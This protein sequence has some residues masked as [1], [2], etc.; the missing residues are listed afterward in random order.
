MDMLKLIGNFFLAAIL[1]LNLYGCVAI[2]A[3]A[4]GGAGTAIW[5]EGKISEQ[6]NTPLEETLR[7]TKQALE[8]LRLVVTKTVVKDEVAQVMAEYYD[9]RTV[10][11][12]IRRTTGQ[13]SQIQIRVGAAGDKEAS[14]KILDRIMRYL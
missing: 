8:S 9:A 4:A 2:I 13:S 12:D 1:L 7:A 6:L 14:Q 3:G 10:W 5:L 11:I